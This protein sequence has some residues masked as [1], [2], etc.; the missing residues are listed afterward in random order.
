MSKH[1]AQLA[2]PP[3]QAPVISMHGLPVLVPGTPPSLPSAHARE[4]KTS[5][6]ARSFPRFPAKLMLR[7]RVGSP[8]AIPTTPAEA[9]RSCCARC[10]SIF[11]AAVRTNKG[12]GGLLLTT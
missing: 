7:S 12:S 5:G 11:P 10:A 2:L 8:A 3:P 9:P 6:N 4:H 1:S